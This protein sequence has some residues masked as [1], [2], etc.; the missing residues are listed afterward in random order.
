MLGC[1][2]HSMIKTPNLDRL[3][4]RGVTFTDAYCN[5]PICVPSR[6]SFHT[7]R[8]PHQTRFWDNA[9]PY[10]GSVPSWGH[11][12]V[13]TGHRATSIGKLHFRSTDDSNGFSE[14]IVPLHVVDGV[15]D[16]LGLI[17]RPL[18]VRKAA[19]KLAS[20]AGC[21][22]SDYQRYDDDITRQADHWLRN[23]AP[24]HSSKPWVLFVSFVCPH[25]PLIARPEWYDLYPEDAVPLPAL[26]DEADTSKPPLRGRPSRVPDSR[27]GVRRAKD[28]ARRSRRISVWSASS[29]TTSAAFSTR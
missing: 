16:P 22:D 28:C 4:A 9:T 2:G 23:E 26:Y 13:E 27:Q 3:A 5:S 21:G 11:R 17:R 8:Y 25:F 20:D 18:P 7:G 24:R 19:L 15:G 6:A 10:D 1:Y 29:T 14:E 12:L